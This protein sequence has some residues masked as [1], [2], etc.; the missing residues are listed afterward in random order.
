MTRGQERYR[1]CS[2]PY[3]ITA[4][5]RRQRRVGAEPVK[6]KPICH[7]EAAGGGTG[8]QGGHCR[9]GVD[10]PDPVPL[11]P[12][13]LGCRGHAHGR[14]C[15]RVPGMRRRHRPRRWH[16][17]RHRTNLPRW[18]A[19]TARDGMGLRSPRRALRRAA[20][21][22]AATRAWSTTGADS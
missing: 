19:R 13:R 6:W 3:R 8:A 9:G 11:M 14:S 2:A 22:R 4:N 10:T 21:M 20:D 7:D 1:L 5:S 16:G 18:M 15:S 12:G 17:Q